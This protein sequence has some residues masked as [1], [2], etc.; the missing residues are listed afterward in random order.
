MAIP[1]ELLFAS[2]F[3]NL[4]EGRQGLC[5]IPLKG[6]HRKNWSLNFQASG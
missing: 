6:T 1:G 3:R 4:E 2:Y 5:S